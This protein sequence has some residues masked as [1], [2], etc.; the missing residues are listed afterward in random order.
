MGTDTPPVVLVV[1]DDGDLRQMLSGLL[2]A[3]AYRVVGAASGED[4]LALLAQGVLPDAILLDLSMPGMG[5]LGFLL[6]VRSTPVYC[7]L[8]VAVVTGGPFSGV[9]GAAIAALGSTLHQK[10]ADLSEILG[11]TARLVASNHSSTSSSH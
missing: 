2:E 1:D 10:P 11:L 5:G 3:E 8:P 9:A 7:H 6:Q 4:A